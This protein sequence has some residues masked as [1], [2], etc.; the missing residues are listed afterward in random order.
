MKKNAY[1]VGIILSVILMA[2]KNEQ[3][4]KVEGEVT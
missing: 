3:T 2:C 4:F 1:I